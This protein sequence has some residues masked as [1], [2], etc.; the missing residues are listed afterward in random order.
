LKKVVKRK[1]ILREDAIRESA[2]MLGFARTGRQIQAAFKS[3]IN[4]AIRRGILEYE[5]DW[6]RRDNSK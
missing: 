6:I 2:R 1:W 4:G 5:D 3:A